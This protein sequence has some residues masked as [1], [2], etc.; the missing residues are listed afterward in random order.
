MTTETEPIE[1]EVISREVVPVQPTSLFAGDTPAAVA[2][3]M[4]ETASALKGIIEDA[5]GSDGKPLLMTIPG[6]PGKYVRCEG[7]T[8]LGAM[9]G[10]FPVNVW[11]RETEDGWEAR[12]EARTTSGAVIG[13]AEAMCSRAENTWAKRDPYALRSMAQTR[14]TSKALRMPLGFVM[15]LA[16][17]EAT[18]AEEMPRDDEPRPY[19]PQGVRQPAPQAQR[20]VARQRTDDRIEMRDGVDEPPK[21]EK[22][23]A[24]R[25][26]KAGT[27]AQGRAYGAFW[28]CRQDCATGVN[29]KRFTVDADAWFNV[30]RT[31]QPAV[32]A[33]DPH[34][35]PQE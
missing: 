1:A 6:K 33:Y 31:D 20:A 15:T 30:H 9:L 35:L 2:V 26:V 4:R 29:G 7:W 28:S 32:E 12:V 14:A 27:T 23:G 24:L 19:R 13:A 3:R 11:T 21:C 16:G 22:H 25:F 10:V 5:H 34:D 8:T 18:P 17:Y